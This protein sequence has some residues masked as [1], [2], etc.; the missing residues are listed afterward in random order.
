M[1]KHIGGQAVVI[2]AGIAGISAAKALADAFDSVVILERD[3]A[4]LPGEPRSGVPQGRQVHLLMSGGFM[5]FQ[6]LFPG[7]HQDLLK[8][9]SIAYTAGRDLRIE[10]ESA[11]TLPRRD[12]G[13]L[14]HAL[15]RPRLEALLCSRLA[16]LDNIA[17]RRGARVSDIGVCREGNWVTG[18]HYQAADGRSEHVEARLV[19]DASGRGGPTITHLRTTG[20]ALPRE[21]V[22]G[23]GLGYASCS[24]SIPEA[25]APNVVGMATL[26][27]PPDGT[28][29][30]YMLRLGGDRW[31]V[32][33]VGRN[34]DWPPAET[35]A[36]LAFADSLATPTIGTALRAGR[37]LDTIARFAFPESVWRHFDPRSLPAGL[38]PI[39]DA[40][41]RLNPVYGQGMTVAA[42][43]ALLLRNLLADHSN[44][45]RPIEALCT[46]FLACT[47][48]L[49]ELP[50]VTSAVPDFAYPFTTGDRP[51]NLDELLARQAHMVQ[52]AFQDAE[53]HRAWTAAQH[54]V[55][56]EAIGPQHLRAA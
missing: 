49:L 44:G 11:G 4:L 48:A 17:I 30:G 26:P 27:A 3:S 13:F 40:I 35:E 24:F 15:P 42:Q 2:G 12:F 20:R 14:S 8:A 25:D 39:G 37:P 19:V 22:I 18:V 29:S 1:N 43:E 10:F 46:D 45:V 31:H 32:A 21:T 41:C 34:D 7:I 51:A 55:R 50:W 56:P 38:I 33:L 36:C 53:A 52:D 47:E 6:Q 5:A 16:A 28:R 23:I 9:G 54:L